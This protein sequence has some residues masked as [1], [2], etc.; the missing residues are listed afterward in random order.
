[1]M[2]T[3]GFNTKILAEDTELTYRLFCSGW[4]VLY[5]NSAECYEE[6]PE[7]WHI[8]AR[9]IARWSRGHNE[10]M[11]RYVWKLVKSK[12]LSFW[13]KLDGMFLLFIYM[14]PVILFLD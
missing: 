13:Q 9:Q 4:K 6:A 7:A 14:M 5:A 2:G 3:D 12:Y 10:V 11:F 1:M 8:R